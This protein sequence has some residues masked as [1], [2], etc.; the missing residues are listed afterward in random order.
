MVKTTGVCAVKG[1]VG[2][3]II[4]QNIANGLSE[5][6]HKVGLI[7]ADLDN[8]CFATFTGCTEEIEIS[9]DK[10]FNPYLWGNIQVFSMSLIAGKTKGVSM[11]E[12]RYA[13]ILDDIVQCSDWDI[14]Y[15]VVDLPSGSGSIFRTAMEIFAK[16]LVGN[17]IISQPSMSDATERMIGLHKY[18]DVPILGVIENMSYFSCPH[19]KEP[20][21]FHLFGKSTV[22][23]LGKKYEVEVLGKIPLN[24]NI[25]KNLAEG[26]PLFPAANKEMLKPIELACEK[27]VDTPI[28]KTSFL[29][30]LKESV[31]EK[32]KPEIEKVILGLL[33]A[34]K[35]DFDVEKVRTEKGFTEKHPF[36][37][38]I[39]DDSGKK[40]ITHVA[41]RLDENGMK[42]IRNPKQVDYEFAL[43][44]KTLAR[45]IM[46]KKKVDGNFIPFDAEDAWLMGDVRV[47]GSGYS[48]R[49]V[50]V[51]R[52]VFKDD[53]LMQQ[54]R[55]KYG[56]MLE[57]WV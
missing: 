3:S 54:M 45:A 50:S 30:K 12:D 16:N 33:L 38:V 21:V 26:N 43:S 23:E 40:E 51:L 24:E 48:P 46:G 36:L 41:M 31:A 22:D 55:D 47:Y 37:L 20:K 7:D 2:K 28:P 53:E 17:I 57:R 44:F 14:E 10:H 4:S 13:Q 8:S 6:G 27:L 9:K 15:L 49:T 52:D 11:T 5:R 35:K 42:I 18:L 32:I 34:L 1:G 29:E 25:A 56:K 39:T 19:H